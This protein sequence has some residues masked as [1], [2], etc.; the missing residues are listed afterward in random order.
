[1]QDTFCKIADRTAAIIG[2][3]W[4]FVASAVLTALWLI[5]G[6]VFRFSDTWPLTDRNS[7]IASLNSP[8]HDNGLVVLWNLSFTKLTNGL[9]ELPSERLR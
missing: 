3:P 1:M 4:T 8:Q 2:S 6:P 7:L 5:L 9:S